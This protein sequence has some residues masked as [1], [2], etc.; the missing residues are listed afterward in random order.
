MKEIMPPAFHYLPLRCTSMFLFF[1][2]LECKGQT[3]WMEM[4]MLFARPAN[5]K[6]KKVRM[7]TF[8]IFHISFYFFRILLD[9]FQE[10]NDKL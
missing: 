7:K 2:R 10:H 5:E 1:L 8:I 9:T 4:C 6:D 3:Y